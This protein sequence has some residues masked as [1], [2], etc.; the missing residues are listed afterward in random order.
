[1]NMVTAAETMIG[2]TKDYF[3]NCH[4]LVIYLVLML[5]AFLYIPE[6]RRLLI[7]PT[8]VLYLIIFNP[9]LYQLLFYRVVYWRLFWMIP[10]TIIMAYMFCQFFKQVRKPYYKV[11]FCLA[12]FLLLCCFG[13]NVYTSGIFRPTANL[14]KIKDGVGEVSDI[15][16]YHKKEPRCLVRNKYLTEMRQYSADIQLVYGRDVYG[17]VSDT[18]K[19]EKVIADSMESARPD[20]NKIFSYAVSKECDFVVTHSDR[21]VDEEL[22][23][24]YKFKEV[25]RKDYSIIYLRE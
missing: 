21:P 1:M 20:Y 7:Y 17:Y 12:S 19:E 4:Y 2:Y 13:N 14:E 6:I 5:V 22:L 11:F 18:P 25:A 16:L 3:G 15:I 10:S 8:I 24:K 23:A 9:I